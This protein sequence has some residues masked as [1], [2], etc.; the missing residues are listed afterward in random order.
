MFDYRRIYVAA[1]ILA[2]GALLPMAALAQQVREGEVVL[3]EVPLALEAPG[4]YRYV[5]AYHDGESFYVD[6]VELF[7][8]LGF[9]IRHVPPVVEALDASRT[10]T[11]NFADGTAR[12]TA[13]PTAHISLA[14]EYIVGAGRYYVTIAGLTALF[15]ADIYFEEERLS[16]RLS[17]AA[18]KFNVGA[19]RKHP[20]LLGQAPGPLR[21]GRTRHLL[22]GVIANYQVSRH[23][24]G[25]QPGLYQGSLSFT[26]SLLGGSISGDIQML[27]RQGMRR[28][29]RVSPAALSYLFDRPGSGLLTRFEVGRFGQ[30]YWSAPEP[31]EAVRLSNL[32][33]TSRYLQR[34]SSFSGQAEPHA[35]VEAVVSGVVVDRAEADAA[36]RYQIVVP[37]FYGST[38]AIVRTRPLGGATPREE[39][40]FLFTTSEL[41]EPG[42]FYYDAYLGR[43]QQT[44]RRVGLVHL[45]YGVLP[46][47]SASVAGI[48][49]GDVARARVGVA[50]SPLSFG[51]V[52][53][54]IDLP[55]GRLRGD[56]K[57]WHSRLSLEATYER[58][59]KPSIL[60]TGKH[61]FQSQLTASWGRLSG[62]VG[63]SF[64]EGF[65]GWTHRRISPA[66]SYYSKRGISASA[67]LTAQRL[68]TDDGTS[69]D[70]YTYRASLGKTFFL[71]EGSSRLSL[72]ARGRG[73]Q[74]VGQSGV[75]GFLSW[76]SV[77]LGFS[78]GYNFHAQDF[79]G[80]LT[81]RLDTPFSGFS[82]RGSY[83]GSMVSHEETLYGSI[84]LGRQ[85]RLTR[86]SL[87]RSS[88]VIRVFEDLSGDGH[89]QVG[90]PLRPEV[91]VQLYQAGLKRQPSGTLRAGFLQP[92]ATYQVEVIERSIRDPLLVPTTGYT[93][94]FIADP[95][96]T[97]RIDIP[98]QRLPVVI[99]YVRGLEIAPPRLRLL[100][101]QGDEQVEATDLYRDGGFTLRLPP[102]RYYAWSMCSRGSCSHPPGSSSLF[103]Q[104][105]RS[106]SWWS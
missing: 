50:F 68:S 66:L 27:R 3:Q 10:Y 23:Q 69:A 61:L 102:G 95:G 45:Q 60:S 73:R 93:F 80:A 91:Q 92:F 97:R 34:E 39:R 15:E 82:S 42:R 7:R 74:A 28:P 100:V 24:V 31:F 70:G 12:R 54:D 21:F 85:P 18:D 29:G 14:G 6:V 67:Q 48:Y 89:Y 78:A 1:L 33:L 40:R 35:L 88:A 32:P 104:A 98:L 106:R 62:F 55:S 90:E 9:E 16:L 96:R 30:S 86:N 64:T 77:S 44:H 43:T 59:P 2:V 47:L 87:Q 57:A 63:I 52:S 26:G 53:A 81:L 72:F 71:P 5:S 101:F 79:T 99:G 13:S 58:G 36:G 17:T 105:A 41:A 38:E 51:V 65:Q 75:E 19:L 49:Y 37:T 76:K 103:N 25:S 8:L 4:Y 22:G 56:V 11:I 84:E 94:S 83:S 46:R 20:R